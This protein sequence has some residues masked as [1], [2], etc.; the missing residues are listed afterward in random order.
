MNLLGKGMT[1]GSEIAKSISGEEL[2]YGFST[3]GIGLLVMLIGVS[4]GAGLISRR[5]L[6]PRLMD[7]LSKTERID[8]NG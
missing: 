7:L 8:G 4:M 2:F 1:I 5:I 3:F 6:F